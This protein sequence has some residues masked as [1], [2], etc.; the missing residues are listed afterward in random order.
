[1]KTLRRHT[2]RMRYLQL[3][4]VAVICAAHICMRYPCESVYVCDCVCDCVCVCVRVYVSARVHLIGGVRS[5][6]YFSIFN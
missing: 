2:Q 3:S 6:V 1:M 5:G 4:A